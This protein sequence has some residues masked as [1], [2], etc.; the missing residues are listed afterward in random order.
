M[1]I[2]QWLGR[3]KNRPG[4]LPARESRKGE[5]ETEISQENEETGAMRK[6]SRESTE[7]YLKL[8][9]QDCISQGSLESQNLWVVSI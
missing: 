1:L 9:E 4:Y 8:Q 7:T 2:T 6:G 3:R 5:R